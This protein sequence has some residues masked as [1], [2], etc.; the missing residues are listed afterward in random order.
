VKT[1]FAPTTKIS[2]DFRGGRLIDKDIPASEKQLRE[3]SVFKGSHKDLFI[4]LT[5]QKLI[6][7]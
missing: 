7:L 3:T 5:S 1:A 4:T 2:R 6:Y